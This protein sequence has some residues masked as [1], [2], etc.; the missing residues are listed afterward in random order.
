M[1]R[2]HIKNYDQKKKPKFIVTKRSGLHKAF[3][4]T[5]PS[6]I[7]KKNNLNILN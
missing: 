5:K 3:N 4:V 2:P 1:I 7:Q 6:I